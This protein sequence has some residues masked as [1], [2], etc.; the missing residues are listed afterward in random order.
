MNNKREGF[1]EMILVNNSLPN[2]SSAREKM[3]EQMKKS[4]E[5]ILKNLREEEKKKKMSKIV[6]S[7]VLGFVV[8]D[9]I[10]VPVEFSLREKLIKNPVR[11]ML[12]YG[13]HSVPDGTWSDDTSMLLATMDSISE[14]NGIYYD[15]MMNRFCRWYSNGEYTGTGKVFDIGI[16]TNNALRKFN[17]GVSALECGDIGEYS[18]G[19]GSLMRILPV[20]LYAYYNNLNDD[21]IIT[22]LNNSSSLTHGHEISKLGCK[23]YTDFI[24]A[25]LDGKDKNEAF[26]KILNTKY[27]IKYSLD[28]IDKYSRLLKSDFAKLD[29]SE[30][31]SSGYVVDTLEASIWCILNTNSYEEAVVKAINLGG[32]TDT[33]GAITGSIAGII[34]GRENI[35][36]RWVTKIRNNEYLMKLIDSYINCLEKN[37]GRKISK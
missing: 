7:S 1:S 36:Q 14:N 10:G 9:A 27:S 31:N 32:D 22:L 11:E 19:N 18:N 8:G 6:Y 30:I 33:I 12:G 28:S 4:R 37:K 13:S 2:D 17:R 35:P 34:Y 23:I 5:L 20:S 29:I 24:I 16:S 15:D 3:I 26:Q 25:I 21:E